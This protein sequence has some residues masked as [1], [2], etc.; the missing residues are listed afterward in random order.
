MPS[1][2]AAPRFWLRASKD[3]SQP[4][5]RPTS[6]TARSL[7]SG[8]RRAFSTSRRRARW[9]IEA[10]AARVRRERDRSDLLGW[11][12]S[13]GVGGR[14]DRRAARIASRTRRRRWQLKCT[15]PIHRKTRLRRHGKRHLRDRAAAIDFR[16]AV[17]ERSG[18]R[19]ER[20]ERYSLRLHAH[21]L[22]SRARGGRHTVENG[23]ALC[24]ECHDA[25]HAHRASDWRA[26]I[27]S[28]RERT[29]VSA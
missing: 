17:L 12:S 6:A 9:P 20:C 21:H 26:W 8:S 15:G 11:R 16:R 22:L 3:D 10:P 24:I 5:S 29:E 28:S 1:W 25:V 13:G 2:A 7:P 23:A 27:W 18:N 19:C 14:R 4:E